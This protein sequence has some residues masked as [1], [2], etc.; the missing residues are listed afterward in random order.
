MNKKAVVFAS[1]RHGMGVGIVIPE[2]I[3]MGS[4]VFKR[5][6]LTLAECQ[7]RGV[8]FLPAQV[9]RPIFQAAGV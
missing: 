8:R 7:K 5:Y 4:K 3:A 9:M 6:E 2:L 1:P